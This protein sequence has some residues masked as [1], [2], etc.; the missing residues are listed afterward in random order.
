MARISFDN[1]ETFHPVE[2]FQGVDQDPELWDWLC[3]QMYAHD[4]DAFSH[5]CGLE[6]EQATVD[7]FTFLGWFL[8]KTET[9]LIIDLTLAAGGGR[10]LTC[11]V[12]DGSCK[13]CG[14]LDERGR[15]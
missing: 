12:V 8:A 5:A 4:A 9:D 10:K 3:A 7:G 1:G 15:K 11:N 14:P 13:V 2:V 6:L